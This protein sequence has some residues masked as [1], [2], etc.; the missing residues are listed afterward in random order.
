MR[1]RR[2]MELLNDYDFALQYHPG[3]DNVVA[4]ALSRKSI[5]SLASLVE[6]SLHL[7]N[8]MQQLEPKLITGRLAALS[9][10]PI[11]LEQ[12]KDGQYIDEYL[13]GKMFEAQNGREGDFK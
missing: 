6:T 4:D 10:R 3:K 9:V 12:I 1:Q 2:W 11:L 8:D 13:L 7:K 5:A